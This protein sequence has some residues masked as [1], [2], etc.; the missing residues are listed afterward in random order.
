MEYRDDRDL[1]PTFPVWNIGTI[2]IF[3]WRIFGRILAG[4][5]WQRFAIRMEKMR[6]NAMT[7]Q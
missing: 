5:S 7:L 3:F 1:F 6:K 4:S 2:G